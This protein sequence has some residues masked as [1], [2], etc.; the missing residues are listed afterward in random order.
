MAWRRWLVVL[1][2]LPALA[3]CGSDRPAAPPA[4][5]SPEEGWREIADG[6][7]FKAGAFPEGRQPDGNTVL[8]RG[9]RGWIVVDTGRHADHAHAIARVATRSRRPVVALVNTHWHLDHVA[10]NAS[11]RRAY[12]RAEVHASRRVAAER[13]GFLARYR[14]QLQDALGARPDDPQ[15]GHWRDEVARIDAGDAYLPTHPVD[16]GGP[17]A[18]DGRM[19]R[20]GLVP[21]AVSG[22]D[23]WIYD[24]ATRVLVAGD[25]VTLPVPLLDTACPTGWS[26]ALRSLAAVPFEQVVP[27][28]GPPLSRR[29]F[30]RYVSAYDRLLACAAGPDPEAACAEAWV[31]DMGQLLPPGQRSQATRLLADYY[32]PRRL[33]GMPERPA[34]CGA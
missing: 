18:L 12:P 9:R 22:G 10:G 15:A 5:P 3:G 30:D 31:A 32:L 13:E 34:Y 26:R 14:A 33:R 28:H 17:R 11:L 29:G 20:F 6:T 23:V 21:D 8:L 25:L 24:A 7:Y 2:G 16:A 27:G 19:L 1:A 4:M